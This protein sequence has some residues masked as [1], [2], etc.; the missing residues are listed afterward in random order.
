MFA[1]KSAGPLWVQYILIPTL[2]VYTR[3]IK[4]DQEEATYLKQ[5]LTEKFKKF[6]GYISCASVPK[7]HRRR[8]RQRHASR[9]TQRKPSTV[10]Q[11]HRTTEATYLRAASPPYHCSAGRS[12][13]C[14]LYGCLHL[15]WFLSLMSALSSFLSFPFRLVMTVIILDYLLYL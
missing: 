5:P 14:L 8:Q 4:E 1:E 12:V 6:G 15:R 13:A 10:Y 7:R 11:L 3:T 2:N 9:A